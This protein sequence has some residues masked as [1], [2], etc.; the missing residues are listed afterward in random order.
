M[1]DGF[2]GNEW[3]QLTSKGELEDKFLRCIKDRATGG[4]CKEI[5]E[6]SR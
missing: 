1:T 6:K 2:S 3:V 5:F 4:D